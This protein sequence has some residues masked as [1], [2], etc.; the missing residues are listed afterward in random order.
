MPAELL[1]FEVSEHTA[2]EDIEVTLPKLH[3]LAHIGVKFSIDD[4][5]TGYSS[6]NHLKRLPLHKLK[7]DQSF[8]RGIGT[9]PEDRAIIDAVVAMA[10]KPDSNC[11]QT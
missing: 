8:V 11:Q 5:G 4:F 10:H 9:S 7:I 2:M 6:L 1:E 3:K